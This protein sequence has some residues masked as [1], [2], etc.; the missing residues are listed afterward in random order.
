M[1]PEFALCLQL[2]IQA[3]MTI[4]FAN[5]KVKQLTKNKM[6]VHPPYIISRNKPSE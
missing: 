4:G 5:M 3:S 6:G 2:P 1:I